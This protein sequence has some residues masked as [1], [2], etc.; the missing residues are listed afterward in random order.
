MAG[1]RSGRGPHPQDE[2]LF[3]ERW[4]GI[5]REA[6]ADLSWLRG[7]GYSETASIKIVGDRYSLKAR[8]RV[9]VARCSCSDKAKE[10]RLA[11]RVEPSR[12]RGRDLYLDGFN[13]LTTFEAALAGGVLL[14]GRD[15]CVRD[16]ASMHGNYRVLSQTGEG[17]C[18]LHE[19]LEKLGPG[20][21]IW[22]LD[23]P[24]SNSGR[25]ASLVREMSRDSSIPNTDVRLVR[26]PDPLLIRVGEKGVIASADSG[27]LDRSGEWVSLAYHILARRKMNGSVID[28]SGC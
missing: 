12:I 20:R 23:R 10:S 11:R 19:E 8:Q 5:L 2:T 4:Q 26:D 6:V 22:Y 21:V 1:Q 17:I 24:V 27:I 14:R 3:A 18:I 28:L 9:A 16:M 13:L 7:R 15:G 25:L